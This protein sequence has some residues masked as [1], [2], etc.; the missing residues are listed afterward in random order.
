MR[1]CFVWVDARH[2]LCSGY[3]VHVCVSGEG[4]P[5]KGAYVYSSQVYVLCVLCVLCVVCVLCVCI[6]VLCHHRMWSLSVC[7]C[8]FVCVCV[9][10]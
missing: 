5:A 6:F 2:P 10:V 1:I 7:V 9:C 4:V 3:I 8:V